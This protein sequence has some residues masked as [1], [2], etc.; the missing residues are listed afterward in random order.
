MQEGGP[1]A[2]RTLSEAG[3]HTRTGAQI[4][5]RWAGDVLDSPPPADR[6]L[7]P[8]TILVAAGSPAS[9]RRLGEISRPIA[10][11]GPIVVAGAGEVG[12][13]L[14]GML[15]D[16]GEEVRVIAETGGPRVTVVGDVLDTRVLDRAGVAE[17]RV[18]VLTAASDSAALLAARVIRDHA[19]EVPIIASALLVENAGRIQKAGA[20]FAL[21]VSQV[22]AQLLSRYVLGEVVSHQP[23]IR[24]A[25][26]EAG[27]LAGQELSRTRIRELTGCSVVA[28]ERGGEVI[29]EF[30]PSFRLAEGDAVYVCGTAAAFERYRE[31]FP[32]D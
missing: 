27:E 19:P 3:I 21:S 30:P 29:M 20:D 26:K 6:P 22:S 5:G 1:L 14:V 28:V 23:R 24:L 11:E 32:S 15:E 4:V 2:D 10:A 16:A 13:N 12:R 18:V 25:R 9:I 7:E 31:A 17:A 8:G